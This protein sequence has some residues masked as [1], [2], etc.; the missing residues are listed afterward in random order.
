MHETI[1]SFQWASGG[2]DFL[3]NLA[4]HEDLAALD[5]LYSAV[6]LDYTTEYMMVSLMQ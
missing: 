1:A 6:F 4:E 5:L 3:L 2:V